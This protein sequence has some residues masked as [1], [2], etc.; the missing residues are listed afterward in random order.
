M[1]EGIVS[2]L[3]TFMV[4]GFVVYY[5]GKHFFERE[6]LEIKRKDLDKI[7]SDAQSKPL[8]ELVDQSNKDWQRRKDSQSK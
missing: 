3:I 8:A 5:V 6:S 1:I 4:L 2:N 7:H